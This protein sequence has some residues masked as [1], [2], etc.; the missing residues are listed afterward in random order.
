MIGLPK[1][2]LWVG[3]SLNR[4]VVRLTRPAVPLR[5]WPLLATAS[6]ACATTQTVTPEQQIAGLRDEVSASRRAQEEL[7]LRLERL[8]ARVAARPVVVAP[9]VA[10]APAAPV[11][12]TRSLPVVRMEAPT[13]RRASAE[14]AP[15]LDT[16][17]PF[18][19]GGGRYPQVLEHTVTDTETPVDLNAIVARQNGVPSGKAKV[20]RSSDDNGD[21]AFQSAVLKYNGGQYMEATEAFKAFAARYPKHSSAGEALYLGGMAF[22]AANRCLD[23]KPM[24]ETVV[25][26]RPGTDLA[27]RSLLSL[28]RCEANVGHDDAARSL[29]NRV[30]S[31]HPSSAAAGQAK[32]ALA[33]LSGAHAP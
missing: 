25:R 7:R 17:I 29:F 11:D 28:A 1:S 20:S 23:G 2:G 13:D 9:P 24:F 12:P 15:D 10:A 32:S 4:A 22:V 27:S 14:S 31:E 6:L 18:R 33:D 16:T 30:V 3:V 19:E 5:L 26:D 8:E 21:E